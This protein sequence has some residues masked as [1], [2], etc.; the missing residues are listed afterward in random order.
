[1]PGIL[2]TNSLARPALLVG[3]WVHFKTV[4]ICSGT[5]GVISV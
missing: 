1:M 5:L 3:W 2:H 4:K